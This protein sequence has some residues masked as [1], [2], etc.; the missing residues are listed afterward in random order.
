MDN[1]ANINPDGEPKHHVV[2]GCQSVDAELDGH[3][4]TPE[5]EASG[6]RKLKWEFCAGRLPIGLKETE[7]NWI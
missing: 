6:G 7:T 4:W 1:K 5:M 3:V 2:S